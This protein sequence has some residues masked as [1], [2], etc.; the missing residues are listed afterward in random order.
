MAILGEKQDFHGQN[1]EDITRGILGKRFWYLERSV[2][3]EGADFLVQLKKESLN[4][5]P[6]RK[7]EIFVLGIVQSK[8][9]Q[10]GTTLKIKRDYC[11][12][13][14]GNPIKQFFLICH[15]LDKNEETIT[16]FLSA[17]DIAKNL[18]YHE[19]D[20]SYIFYVGS[21][22]NYSTFK[23][24]QH[25][26]I[27]DAIEGGILHAE[28]EKN[29]K[30]INRLFF[31]TKEAGRSYHQRCIYLLRQVEDVGVVIVED[32][33]RGG[34]ELLEPRRDLYKC[35]GGFSWGYTGEGPKF[36]ANCLLSH[37]YDG[38]K[39]PSYEVE[40][41]LHWL[42]RSLEQNKNWDIPQE[43]VKAVLSG[44]MVTEQDIKEICKP[45][46]DYD[47]RVKVLAKESL[48]KKIQ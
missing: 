35:F 45:S 17:E 5:L 11:I 26:K 25:K 28:Q 18:P 12:D 6:S 46:A 38:E 9:F 34:K 30:Y 16:Y 23:N 47:S 21:Q 10:T 13:N 37:M 40:T 36:L 15:T 27:L 4:E 2:D 44:V 41:I 7:S 20:D 39:P 1:G 32:T 24:N 33:N 43:L 29:K 3:I 22:K 19:K 8:F 42:I 48:L 14:E 31:H